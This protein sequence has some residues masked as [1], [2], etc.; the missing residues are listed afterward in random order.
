VAIPVT[1]PVSANL[2]MAVWPPEPPADDGRFGRAT[3]TPTDPVVAGSL[4]TWTLTYVAG[5]H[6]IDDGGALRIAFHT[7]PYH[8]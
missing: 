6:G 7:T 2:P 1:T 5:R 4:G 8:E 3:L